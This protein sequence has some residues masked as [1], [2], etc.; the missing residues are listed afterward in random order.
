MSKKIRLLYMEGVSPLRSQTVYHAVGY[1]MNESTPNTIIMVSPNGPYVSIG[2]HQDIQKEVDLDYCEKH[3][4][5]VYR[6]E[7]GGGARRVSAVHPATDGRIKS[8]AGHPQ[9]KFFQRGFM[10]LPGVHTH[11][12]IHQQFQHFMPHGMR[13]HGDLSV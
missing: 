8:C 3:N 7:V 9:I 6:R 5:P 2:Y 12:G 1:A 10:R 4:L 11:A 13:G